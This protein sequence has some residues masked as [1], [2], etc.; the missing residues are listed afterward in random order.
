LGVFHGSV[1][2]LVLPV[3]EKCVAQRFPVCGQYIFLLQMWRILFCATV[4]VGFTQLF[5]R[6]VHCKDKHQTKKKN[7]ADFWGWF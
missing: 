5:D 1:I 4:V 7:G 6:L 2:D 3:Q